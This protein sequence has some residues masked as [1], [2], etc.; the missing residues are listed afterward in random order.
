MMGVAAWRVWRTGGGPAPLALYGAQLLLNFAWTPLFFV[1]HDLNLAS[2]D[3]LGEQQRDSQSTRPSSSGNRGQCVQQWQ[4]QRRRSLQRQ[5]VH[6]AHSSI[7]SG[8]HHRPLR[9]AALRVPIAGSTGLPPPESLPPSACALLRVALIGVLGATIFEFG[10]VDQAAALLLLPYLGWTC[11]ATALTL[12]I[13]AN[14]PDVSREPATGSR[15]AASQPA[16][17]ADW[18]VAPGSCCAAPVSTA[19]TLALS[20]LCAGWQ[21]LYQGSMTHPG[22]SW[23]LR[24]PRNTNWLFD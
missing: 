19:R 23:L 3:I 17:L 7:S 18:A 2:A 22:S 24:P 13:R 11:F 20:P 5:P 14:N 8:Q 16:G 1:K 9:A 15:Q 4:Q 6:A 21:A 10:K 12:N